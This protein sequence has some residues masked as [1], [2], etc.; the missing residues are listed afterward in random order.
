LAAE[1]N[2]LLTD[3]ERTAKPKVAVLNQPELV[4]FAAVLGSSDTTLQQ[5]LRAVESPRAANYFPL[6]GIWRSYAA[7]LVNLHRGASTEVVLPKPKGHEHYYLP[8]VLLMT[9]VDA[10][11]MA[12]AR[13]A[14]AE[15]FE[16]RNRDRR[17]TDWVG[18]DGDGEK[19]VR[20]DF[21]LFAI[22]AGR[23]RRC[24]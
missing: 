23:T 16:A 1:N 12:N 21:R 13:V 22:E 15:G 18:L 20:W 9:A 14:V 19:P 7:A 2:G 11:G 3:L 24:P 4:H 10:Q 6:S 17:F 8:Y 5:L